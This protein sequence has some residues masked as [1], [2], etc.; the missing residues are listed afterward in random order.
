MLA[1]S[2]QLGFKIDIPMSDRRIY[3]FPGIGTGAVAAYADKRKAFASKKVM[4]L[5]VEIHRDG[6]QPRHSS[7]TCRTVSILRI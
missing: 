5:Q 7:L 6:H 1:A 2:Y 4:R 3:A